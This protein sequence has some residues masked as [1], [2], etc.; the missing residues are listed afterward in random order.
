MLKS[1][2][3]DYQSL[4]LTKLLLAN[5]YHLIGFFSFYN[6]LL[7]FMANYFCRVYDILITE[8]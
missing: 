4:K 5:G 6:V 8:I 1:K 7:I 2:F 3:C